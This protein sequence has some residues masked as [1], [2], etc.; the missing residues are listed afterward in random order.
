MLGNHLLDHSAAVSE[1]LL[2]FFLASIEIFPSITRNP[3]LIA[4]FDL[5]FI[6][7]FT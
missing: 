4:F 3:P 6:R 1:A 2:V 5:F 7:I